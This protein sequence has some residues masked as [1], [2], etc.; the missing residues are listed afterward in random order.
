MDFLP[1]DHRPVQTHHSPERHISIYASTDYCGSRNSVVAA[2]VG[3]DAAVV[4]V[5]VFDGDAGKDVL[6]RVSLAPQ[7]ALYVQK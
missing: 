2:A 5:V 3:G 7:S 4:V 6:V 1:I